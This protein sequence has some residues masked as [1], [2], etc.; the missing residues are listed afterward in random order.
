MADAAKRK[1]FE[2]IFKQ[3]SKFFVLL[4]SDKEHE[5][6]AALRKLLVTIKKAGLD[7]H[8]IL[9]L[10]TE[11]RDFVSEL[12]RSLFEDDET[13]L[14]RLTADAVLFCDGDDAYADIMHDG[15]RMT[16][17]LTGC[18]FIDWLEYAFY[19]EKK[20]APQPSAIKTAVRN[21][22]ARARFEGERHKTYLRVACVN[23]VIYLDLGDDTGNAVMIDASGWRIAANPPVRFRRTRSMRALPI[24]ERGGS[25]A[26]LR[27][28][29]NVTDKGFTLFVA[30]LVDALRPGHPHPLYVLVGEE[31]SAK[32]EATRIV[33]ELIDPGM[34][35]TKLCTTAR[36]LFVSARNSY[37]LGFDNVSDIPP[38]IS[39][40]LCQIISGTGY[41][42]RKLF[43]DADQ[44]GW[45]ARS[46]V[47]MNG[48]ANAITRADL[49]DRSV[50]IDMP[51]MTDEHREEEEVLRPEF[52]RERPAILGALLD[53]VARGL[54]RW[55]TVRLIRP[56]RMA[57]FARWAVA[58]EQAPGDFM[59]AFIGARAE[60]VETVLEQDAVAT[61]VRLHMLDRETWQGTAGQLREMRMR[62]HRDPDPTRWKDWPRDASQLGTR[63]RRL[64]KVLRAAG[65]EVTWK[66]TPDRKR[67]RLYTLRV[68]TTVTTAADA[69]DGADRTDAAAPKTPRAAD[70]S[71]S[72]SMLPSGR[73]HRP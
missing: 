23:E 35:P 62:D 7:L 58:C 11:R 24:P 10:F 52:E 26:H 54:A 31:G 45:S 33:C 15:H 47:V 3:F 2:K 17:L 20:K 72:R 19:A 44:A 63:L 69:T 65:V 51:R 55:P 14:L 25:L 12:L 42:S 18:E 8:D 13:A 56:P 59:R 49:A 71:K 46:A 61:A 4:G 67:D 38:P 40:A 34:E 64:T 60:A 22:R 21:L 9:A 66:R 27:R 39:D 70:A 48:I 28:F 5:A 16:L 68:V 30:C 1:A 73:P 29:I 6:M 41:R 43:S 36:D 32:T 50:V 37:M 53:Q 57:D